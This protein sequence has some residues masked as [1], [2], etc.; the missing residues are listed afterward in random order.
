MI[1]RAQSLKLPLSLHLL[2]I[3]AVLA[4]RYIASPPDAEALAKHKPAHSSGSASTVSSTVIEDAGSEDGKELAHMIEADAAESLT[5]S[6]NVGAEATRATLSDSAPSQ[7]STTGVRPSAD[8]P[9]LPEAAE[10]LHASSM[11]SKTPG[12]PSEVAST[13]LGHVVNV[14][15]Q[16][17]QDSSSNQQPAVQ[18]GLPAEGKREQP[19]QVT[20]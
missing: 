9:G 16:A 1:A 11:A 8:T 13:L 15:Q 17:D 7:C 18:A 3:C 19:S 20:N 14:S 2:V 12:L 5:S 10:E 4:P 6:S